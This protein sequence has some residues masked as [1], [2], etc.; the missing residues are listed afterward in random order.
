MLSF[1]GK[2]LM[3]LQSF[4]AF[5]RSIWSS[6]QPTFIIKYAMYIRVSPGAGKPAIS[7][8]FIWL[9]LTLKTS[10]CGWW[11]NVLCVKLHTIYGIELHRG[12]VS[13]GFSMEKIPLTWKILGRY[14]AAKAAKNCHIVNLDWHCEILSVFWNLVKIV[15]FGWNCTV[16]IVKQN[17]GRLYVDSGRLSVGSKRLSWW[18]DKSGR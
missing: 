4:A 6:W 13:V 12:G 17:K 18:V 9:D 3:A 8:L 16:R 1:K 2:L 5:L 15:I 7:L 11:D 10:L 14:I